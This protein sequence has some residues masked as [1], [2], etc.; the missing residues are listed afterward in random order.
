[1]Q[2]LRLRIARRRGVEARDHLPLGCA[3]QR[4]RRE[5]LLGVGDH[6]REKPREVADQRCDRRSLEPLGVIDQPERELRA[7]RDL[8]GQ[9][10]VGPLGR[11]H[12]GDPDRARNVGQRRH[13]GRIV[14]ERHD[15]LEQRRAGGQFGPALHRRQRTVL[16]VR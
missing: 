4:Q 13:L 2:A 5:R 1:M 9:R 3:Q 10:I 14:L 8:Q 15:A 16:I 7:D 6:L 11:P 12:V